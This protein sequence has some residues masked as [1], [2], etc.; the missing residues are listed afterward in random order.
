MATKVSPESPEGQVNQKFAELIA[1]RTD[2]DVDLKI[3]WSE[4]LGDAQSTLEQVSDGVIDIYSE[5]VT[6]LEKW[7]KDISWVGAP[8]VFDDRDHWVCFLQGGYFHDMLSK[9]TEE[10]GITV[11]GEV[12]PVVRGP[13]RVILSKAPID[14]IDDIGNLKLRIWDNDLMVDVWSALGAEVRV[15]GWTDVYQSIQTGIVDSVTS[16]ASLVEP[17]KFTE[18]AP[19]ISRTDEFN[20]AVS[21]M[22]NKGSWDGLS[23]AQREGILAAY[24]ET[25]E[26][27]QTLVQEQ[28]DEALERLEAA[29]VTY[30]TLDTGPFIERTKQ[31]YEKKAT[32]GEI[33]EGFLEAVDAA[34][35]SCG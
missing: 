1:E 5:D 18:V 14:G 32:D 24:D 13:Y 8:F 9:T 35:S 12:G 16:P 17:M 31:I 30:T 26:Y 20:Q 15:L 34:R 4:Q 29:G 27:S 22:I 2:G 23:D 10:S 19:H 25:G 11:I 7:N 6:Y 28:T 21:Y 3:Y 33:P